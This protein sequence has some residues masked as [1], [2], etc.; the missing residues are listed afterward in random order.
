MRNSKQLKCLPLPSLP[1]PLVPKTHVVYSLRGS[2]GETQRNHRAYP[3]P[4]PL[5]LN[6]SLKPPEFFQNKILQSATQACRSHTDTLTD[7]TR[8][9][10]SRGLSCN[11]EKFETVFFL[12]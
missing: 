10:G 3:S 9:V 11:I 2:G 12:G 1:S 8:R 5:I 6:Y 4:L 7:Q